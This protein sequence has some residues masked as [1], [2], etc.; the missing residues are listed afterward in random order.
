MSRD[1]YLI[2]DTLLTWAIIDADGHTRHFTHFPYQRDLTE[3]K[4]DL[5]APWVLISVESRVT[6]E[7][8]VLESVSS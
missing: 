5:R 8:I 3:A 2:G 6:D 7:S 4:R 1:N